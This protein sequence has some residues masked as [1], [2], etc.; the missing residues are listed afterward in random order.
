M[1][2]EALRLVHLVTA[3][4]AALTLAVAVLLFIR[5]NVPGIIRSLAGTT[6]PRRAPKRR[7]SAKNDTA[8]SKAAQSKTPPKQFSQITPRP[9]AATPATE[10]LSQAAI[11]TPAPP[12]EPISPPPAALDTVAPPT[13]QNSPAFE[14]EYDITYVHT[15]ESII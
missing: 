11:I 4:L 9:I 3:A 13:E 7:R 10:P 8:Q 1:T 12:T 15:D 5:F 2:Y 6:A 14:L